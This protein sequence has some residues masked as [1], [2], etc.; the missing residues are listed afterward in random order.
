M[1][2]LRRADTPPRV[3]KKSI[4]PAGLFKFGGNL[5]QGQYVLLKDKQPDP[6]LP[7]RG[8]FE[9]K[10]GYVGDEG[11]DLADRKKCDRRREEVGERGWLA[12]SQSCRLRGR[13]ECVADL[14]VA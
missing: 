14:R 1:R 12:Q 10:K 11:P 5:L 4:Y 8:G 2:R 6:E 7:V 3:Y 9:D 13:D